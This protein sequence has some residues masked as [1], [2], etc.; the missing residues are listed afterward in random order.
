MSAHELLFSARLWE[1]LDELVAGHAVIIDRARGSAH[2]RYPHLVYPLDYGYLEGTAGGDGGGVD[3]WI[4]SL[5]GR[6]LDAVALT[7]DL[8]KKDAEI[9]LLLGCSPEEKKE[10]LAFHNEDS[11]AAMLVP[12]GAAGLELIHARRSVRR[13]LPDAVPESVLAQ[14]LQ[15]ALRAPSAH[16]KQ[17]WRFVI[18]ETAR[19]R[20]R[21]ADA[22]GAE[23]RRDSLADGLSEETVEI[24]VARSKARINGAPAAVLVCLD[25]STLDYYDDASRQRAA[26]LMMVHSVA[27]AGQNLLLAAHGLGLGGV[28]MCAPLFA[29]AAA[30]QSLELPSNWEPQGLA[31]LGYPEK[32][33]AGRERKGIEEVTIRR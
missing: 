20:Q 22:M 7:V 26:Y 28:W 25:T 24:M 8:L 19:S 11:M 32:M 29:Q 21:L 4:G 1:W 12:R 13:F 9:K 14:V 31:L 17:P 2:P 3:V 5:A 18:L 30:S 15:A 23:L 27:M 10:V 6:R 33:P 16:N